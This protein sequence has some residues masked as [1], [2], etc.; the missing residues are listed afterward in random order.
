MSRFPQVSSLE[1]AD[2]EFNVSKPIDV[3]FSVDVY[4][5]ILK[6]GRILGTQ[7]RRLLPTL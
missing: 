2:P 7:I 5:D 3:L 1:L 6:P 4:R